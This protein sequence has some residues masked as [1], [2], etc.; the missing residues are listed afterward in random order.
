MTTT[1]SPAERRAVVLELDTAHEDTP[2]EEARGRTEELAAFRTDALHGL[3][4][5]QKS[6]PSKYL[7]DAI[8]AKLFEDITE[9][10]EYY[11]TRT[12]ASLLRTHAGAIAAA[13]GPGVTIVEPGS[14]AGEKVEILID[15]LE[16]PR[17]MVPMDIAR[18]QLRHVAR[19]LAARH[20]DLEIVPLWADFTRPID[21]PDRVASLH[22]RLV[23]FPGSTIGNFLPSV[24]RELLGS[25]AQLAGADGSLLIGFD[26][27]KDESVL[28]P[29]YDDAAGVTR[30][31]ELNILERMNRELDADADP[32]A[33]EYQARWNAEHARIE[34]HLV[35]TREHAI[36]IAG[37]RFVFARG[38]SL[39]NE[40]SHKYDMPRIESL[41][42]SAGLRVETTWSDEKDWFTLALLRQA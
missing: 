16:S 18:E 14:G 35:A 12:E 19:T 2:L 27:I 26:R 22:P 7:Y 28:I 24:Q 3:G 15:A 21:L 25:L 40:S 31:F 20:T 29:A 23:F 6:I 8:G 38:E 34:M 33:F 11:P 17:A 36:T 13:V 1:N 4:Q 9:Q 39:W 30:A 10:P 32:G 41:A 42:A 37:Q 5:P